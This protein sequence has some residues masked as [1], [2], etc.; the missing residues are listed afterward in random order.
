[1]NQPET[2]ILDKA[3]ASLN[4]LR[5][6]A[7]QSKQTIVM[8]THDANVARSAFRLLMFRDGNIE[9]DIPQDEFAANSQAFNVG[10]GQFPKLLFANCERSSDSLG[11]ESLMP[12]RRLSIREI[13]SRPA[14]SL[15]TLLSIVIGV[16][17]MVA[18][19]LASDSAQLGSDCNGSRVTGNAS[20][21][22]EAVGGASFDGKPLEPVAKLPGVKIASPILRRYSNMTVKKCRWRKID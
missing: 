3:V 15:L 20:L 6:L 7:S 21:E 8:V 16:S 19:Y 22:I 11:G 12:L 5:D 14:R 1:M 10:S 17:A 4:C 13:R 2:S 18:T 9:R